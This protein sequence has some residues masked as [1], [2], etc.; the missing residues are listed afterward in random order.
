[1][2]VPGIVC[3]LFGAVLFFLGFRWLKRKRL[4][5][6]TPTSKVRSLAMGLA[7]VNGK[8]VKGA[9]ILKGPLS[10]KDCVYYKY[11]VEEYRRSGKNSHWVTIEQVEK[12]VHFFLE[13]DTGAVLVDPARAEVDVPIELETYNKPDFFRMSINILPGF[14]LPFGEQ[15]RRY[16]EWNI[17][18]NDSLYILGI[19]G[20]NPFIEEG[21]AATGVMDVMMQKGDSDYYISNKSEKDVLKSLTW[22]SFGGIFAGAALMLGGLALIL[23]YLKVF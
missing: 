9:E 3:I 23:I 19:A 1:M 14:N 7:E 10:Q 13:D 2:L 6:G 18:A 15:K 21:S 12:G 16:K 4:I 8:V 20:D 22:K 5:E 11:T 17:E